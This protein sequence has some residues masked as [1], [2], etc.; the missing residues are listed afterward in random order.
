M[1]KNA[2]KDHTRDVGE[3]QLLI[4]EHLAKHPD[5]LILPISKALRKDY[6][7]VNKATHKLYEM[8]Y[9]S[10]RPGKSKK[11]G[12]HET[13]RLNEKGL[14]YVLAFTNTDIN[15]IIEVYAQHSDSRLLQFYGNLGSKL[16][17]AEL[18]NKLAKH[19]AQIFLLS[20][21]K[22]EADMILSMSTA[23]AMATT[24]FK[25]KDKAKLQKAFKKDR[26][27]QRDIKR[28]FK[29]LGLELMTANHREH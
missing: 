1:V 28:L 8:G 29:D 13:Y 7:N 19:G 23:L 22:S 12:E 16:N 20:D 24:R 14:C 2:L 27:V 10:S 21:K 11:G 9:L 6:S 15:Q 26:K 5:Q 25:E 17:D 3:I 18:L 4:L